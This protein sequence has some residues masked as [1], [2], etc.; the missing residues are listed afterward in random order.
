VVDQKRKENPNLNLSV[1]IQYIQLYKEKI[2]DLFNK[3]AMKVLKENKL[4]KF[5]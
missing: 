3:T 2:Y 4:K 1:S 5:E